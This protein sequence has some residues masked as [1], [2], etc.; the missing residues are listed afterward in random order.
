MEQADNVA[1]LIKVPN[2]T[3]LSPAS[4]LEHILQKCSKEAFWNLDKKLLLLFKTYTK[5]IHL[6]TL[7]LVGVFTTKL[8]T[9]VGG[10]VVDF[11]LFVSGF[12]FFST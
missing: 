4:Q 8:K 1:F 11:L 6:Q 7:V 9:W 12:L 3:H 10:R 5:F 2:L